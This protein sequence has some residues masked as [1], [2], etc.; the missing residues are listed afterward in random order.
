MHLESKA[1]NGH[2]LFLLKSASTHQPVHFYKSAR[3]EEVAANG[4]IESDM[5]TLA[6]N[7][8]KYQL[9]RRDSLFWYI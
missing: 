5:Y 8:R 4:R 6:D 3:D 2:R 1:F 7:I 9:S